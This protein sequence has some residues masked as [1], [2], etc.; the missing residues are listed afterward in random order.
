M[1]QEAGRRH[2]SGGGAQP[3]SAMLPGDLAQPRSS[4]VGT[5]GQSPA[6]RPCRRLRISAGQAAAQTNVHIAVNMLE[7]RFRYAVSRPKARK[8]SRP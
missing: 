1:M 4:P 8:S 5:S 2:R 6:A 7:E 3:P